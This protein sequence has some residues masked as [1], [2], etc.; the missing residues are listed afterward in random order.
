MD[1]WPPDSC[2]ILSVLTGR[3]LGVWLFIIIL[4]MFYRQHHLPLKGKAASLGCL[5]PA[6]LGKASE[7]VVWPLSGCGGSD[8]TSLHTAGKPRR[9]G[10]VLELG[11]AGRLALR[12]VG[13]G[14]VIYPSPECLQPHGPELI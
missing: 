3:E 5:L 12:W 13:L 4:L 14:T 6:M 10:L 11:G 7:A 9:A 2:S 1:T 8:E